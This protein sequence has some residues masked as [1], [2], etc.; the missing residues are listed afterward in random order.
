MA[1]LSDTV[2]AEIRAQFQ[3]EKSAVWEEI[4][5]ITKAELGAAIAATDAWIDTN[6]AA[7]NAAIPLPAR[8]ALT[9]QQKVDLFLLVLVRRVKG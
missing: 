9:A 3:R 2:R 4:P 8:T 1:L 6:A 5:I 7:F